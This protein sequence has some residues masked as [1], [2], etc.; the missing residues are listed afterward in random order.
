MLR[1][2]NAILDDTGSSILLWNEKASEPREQ[3]FAEGLP[4]SFIGRRLASNEKRANPC[5]WKLF[6]L[7]KMKRGSYW[8]PCTVLESRHTQDK[9]DKLQDFAKAEMNGDAIIVKKDLM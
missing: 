4:E 7:C 6:Y 3:A 8:A 9:V 1:Y 5:S 2:C